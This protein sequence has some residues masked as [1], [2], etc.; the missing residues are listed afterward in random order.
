[1]PETANQERFPI[2]EQR[3]NLAVASKIANLA[4]KVS[5]LVDDFS[6]VERIPRYVD[7]HRENDVEHSYMLAMATPEIAQELNQVL[8]LELDTDKVRRFAIVHD[9]LEVK[10][11]DVATFD[12]TPAQLAEKERLEQEAK[13]ELY[14]ELP[15]QTA[16]DLR[17][18][19]LKDTPEAVFV[20]LVDKL[21]PVAVNITG[22]GV[23]VFREDY[24]ITN[25]EQLRQSYQL[26]HNRIA[27]QFGGRFP[28]VVAAHAVLC[29]IFEQKFP[30]T[31]YETE[32]VEK[33][34]NLTEVELK[35]LVDPDTLHEN[36]NLKAYP[37]KHIRQGYIAIGADGSEVRVRCFDDER[38]ELTTKS[39]GM[40][41]RDEQT[42]KLSKEMFEDLWHQTVG[43]RVV[44]TRYYIPLDRNTIELDV[45]EEHLK[46]LITAEVEFDGRPTEAMV[47][48]TT[49]EPPKWFGKNISEDPRYKNRNLVQRIPRDSMP[50]DSE[51]C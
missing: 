10:V 43:R 22:D 31:N 37:K 29:Q 3:S 42:V 26:L 7:G 48:A 11:G 50:L 5:Q 27:K 24:G 36:M 14:A 51:E 4:I 30:P 33:P 23:R 21:L 13:K 17:E 49:F 16:K 9:L 46:G 1:M 20:R 34:R 15:R 18:Y 39:P 19:E 40:I 2:L 25:I 35:Y 47:R 12:L 6:D 45:Y 28:E 38:F 8:N 44:K 41:A 32:A